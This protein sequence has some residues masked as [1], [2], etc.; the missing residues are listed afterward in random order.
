MLTLILLIVIAIC[1]ILTSYAI[2]TDRTDSDFMEVLIFLSGLVGLIL[3][4]AVLLCTYEYYETITLADQRI[5][6]YAEQNKDIENKV[7]LVVDKYLQHEKDT[8]GTLKPKTKITLASIYPELQSNKLV[9]QQI[10]LYNENNKKITN[11]K[12]QK[13][14]SQFYRKLIIPF[15]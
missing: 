15:S 12:L 11:C 5:Q 7:G 8:Y 4:I 3:L 2:K 14:E 13:I 6:L 1:I 9:Q 10:Q